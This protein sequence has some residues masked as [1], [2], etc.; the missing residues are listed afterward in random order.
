VRARHARHFAALVI[1]AAPHLRARG[2]LSWLARL[3]AEHD[4]VL[5]AMRALGDEGEAGLLGKTVVGLMWFWLLSGSRQEVLAWIEFARAVPGEADRLDQLLIDSVHALVQIIPGDASSGDPWAALMETLEEVKDADLSQHPLLAAVRPMLA[6]AIGRERVKELLEHS[7]AHPDPWV[8]ATVPFVRVQILENEGDVDGMR[9]A[10]DESLRAFTEVGDRWGLAT[11]LSELSSLRVLEGDLDGAEQALQQTQSLLAELGASDGGGMVRMRLS[12]VR[13]RQGDLTGAQRMLRESLEERERYAEESAMIKIALAQ[14]SLLL[15]EL[16]PARALAAEALAAL[17]SGRFGPPEQGH[18]RAMALAGSA[19]VAIES[20]ELDDAQR[21]LRE[22]YPVAVQTQ[23][24]PIVA[25]VGV[26]IAGLAHAWGRHAES[27]EM[28]GAAA[29]LRGA[30]DRTH[31]MI[32]RLTAALRQ[33]LG[34]AAFAAAFARGR[35]L[36]RDVALHRLAP[37]PGDPSSRS[38]ATRVGA[39]RERHED[40]QQDPHPGERPQH[41]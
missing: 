11:T 31:P 32:V 36:E 29:R 28:L 41:V 13:A 34:E 38:D 1:A 9:E 14:V 7:A 2:Q 39:Q 21:L 40:G 35:A 20:G 4:N 33:E 26:P 22:A 3:H 30:E 8:R 23:D 15:G 27:A 5:A 19:L 24:M 10:L 12:D 6:V 17:R 25:L 18:A 37:D 16:E